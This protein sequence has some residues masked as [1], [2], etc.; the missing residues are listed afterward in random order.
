M[1]NGFLNCVLAEVMPSEQWFSKEIPL[2]KC[3]GVPIIA[4]LAAAVAEDAAALAVKAVEAGADAGLD[5][6]EV[7]DSIG[8]VMLID[9]KTGQ[10]KLGGPRGYGGLS[11]GA[12]KPIALRM[13]F[14]IAQNFSL[15][16]IASGG[17]ETA[18]DCIEYSMAG[19]SFFGVCT[20]G[21]LQ[22]RARYTKLIKDLG[23]YLDENKI[24]LDEIRG[25]SLKKVAERAEKG[26]QAI[27]KAIPPKVDEKLCTGCGKCQRAC[28]YDAIT[29]QNKKARIDENL[30]YGCGCCI[31]ICPEEAIENFYY[32]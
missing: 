21:H 8:P 10:P 27:T 9:I 30:C 22:G 17:I 11:G 32:R 12:L 4:N 16:I 15:P 26:W 24:V 31:Y 1:P 6:V 5:A 18:E 25:L 13:V 3:S 14:E 19:A 7:T 29:L 28:I 20:V 2:A 23:S